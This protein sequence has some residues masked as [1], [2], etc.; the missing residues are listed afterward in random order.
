MPSIK[1]FHAAHANVLAVTVATAAIR[2][3]EVPLGMTLGMT[4]TVTFPAIPTAAEEAIEEAEN[5]KTDHLREMTVT[6]GQHT[7]IR[8]RLKNA[9]TMAGVTGRAPGAEVRTP[10]SGETYL[11]TEVLTRGDDTSLSIHRRMGRERDVFHKY[12]T[13]CFR[14]D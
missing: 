2:V 7:A 11:G 1:L 3:V 9:E 12:P 8:M 5:V 10:E 13:I 6:V 4:L 14:I